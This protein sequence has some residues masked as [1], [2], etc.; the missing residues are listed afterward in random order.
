ML[1]DKQGYWL[2]AEG[3]VKITGDKETNIVTISA[4]DVADGSETP[5]K[6]LTYQNG[7]FSDGHGTNLKMVECA[8]QVYLTTMPA[9]DIAYQKLEPKTDGAQ[10]RIDIDNQ[11]WLR[12]NADPYDCESSSGG[13]VIKSNRIAGLPG[14]ISFAG[15]KKV[16]T[17]D[18]AN[19]AATGFRDQVEVAL[20]DNDGATWA[21]TYD[22]VYSPET[23]AKTVAPGGNATTIGVE[24][25]NEWLKV[26]EGAVL[27][28]QIPSAG[29]ILVLSADSQLLYNSTADSGDVYVPAGSYVELAGNKGDTFT[30]TAR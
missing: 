6:A 2:T 26:S 19:M 17:P 22:M 12:R 16:E 10:L 24:G 21:R 15:I 27:S 8:G 3:L 25:Y 20:F 1:L 30:V 28:F 23:T 18:F 7:I 14:Y 4:I 9:V 11:M 5:I 29:R 13:Y